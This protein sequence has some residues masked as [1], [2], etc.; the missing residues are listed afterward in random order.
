MPE[1]LKEQVNNRPEGPRVIGKIQAIFYSDANAVRVGGFSSRLED[2]LHQ[3][4]LIHRAVARF[5]VEK[6]LAGELDADHKLIE[7]KIISLDKQIAS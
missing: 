7:K 6:A 3:V 2:A 5:F 1:G 4:D